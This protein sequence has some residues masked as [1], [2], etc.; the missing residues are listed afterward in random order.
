VCGGVA[1]TIIVQYVCNASVIGYP[2]NFTVVENPSC[3]YTLMV[4]T[5]FACGAVADNSSSLQS[6]NLSQCA[7]A[8][9]NLS[10]LASRDLAAFVVDNSYGGP[11]YVRPCTAPHWPFT[12]TLRQLARGVDLKPLLPSA[13]LSPCP[14]CV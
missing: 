11:Y 9:F 5:S 13:L 6:P 4:Q 1:R 2:A 12:R 7:Y 3:T 10:S 8:G 14:L